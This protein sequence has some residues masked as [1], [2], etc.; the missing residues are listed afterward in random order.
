MTGPR[1]LSH[2][3]AEE[4]ISAS[5][6]GDLADPEAADLATHLAGCD[7]CTATAAAWADSRRLL[8]GVRHVAAPRDLGARVRTGIE[9]GRLVPVPWWRRP[10]VGLASAGAL[11]AAALVMAI[12]IGLPNDGPPVASSSPLPTGVSPTPS[13][14]ETPVATLS[15]VPTGPVSASP[16][17]SLAPAPPDYRIEYA[18]DVPG[19]ISQ[20]LSLRVVEQASGAVLRTLVPGDGI[21]AGVPT[22]AKLSPDGAWLAIRLFQDGKGTDIIYAVQLVG[23]DQVVFI[24]ESRPDPFAGRLLWS[25]DGRFL[26]ATLVDFESGA[27]DVTAFEPATA[28]AVRLT[29]TGTAYAGSWQTDTILWMSLAGADPVS[30]PFDLSGGLPARDGELGSTGDP[31]DAFL[32]L[33]SPDGETV[34]FWRG[35]MG[36][37]SGAWAFSNG[38]VLNLAA[39][40]YLEGTSPDV[41]PLFAD[42]PG[43]IAAAEVA[44]AADSDAYAV[45]GLGYVESEGDPRSV[46]LGHLSRDGG[47]VSQRQR[48]DDADVPDGATVRNV[49]LAP[50][51]R[52][53]AITASFP[54]PGDLAQ[55]VAELVLVTR[56]YDDRPDETQTLGPSDV[57]VGP[58]I[59]AP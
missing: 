55:P 29:G 37:D 39:T 15:P 17:P 48:L 3:A 8:S 38:G 50:D 21:L 19:N 32:P 44:W 35:Q 27:A 18:F 13:N 7:R 30:Y 20:G 5:L 24:G 9:R 49:A 1:R 25:P 56:N 23:G 11:A 28:A 42:A 58:G 22:E 57:W 51:G 41:A 45:W 54:M 43:P 4:L 2:A 40:A 16:E 36:R 33:F 53:L 12:I 14:S 59:Y 10:S 6:T 52:H 34:I 26:V 47:Q 31:V 46:Y